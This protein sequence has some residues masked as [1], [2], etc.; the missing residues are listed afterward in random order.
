MATAEHPLSAGPH[1]CAPPGA[2]LP[3]APPRFTLDRP[4]LD[5]ALVAGDPV[6]T[7]LR[8]VRVLA[9][10]LSLI[11]VAPPRSVFEVAESVS[12]RV[13]DD[14]CAHAERDPAAARSGGWEY[15]HLG[16]G[17]WLAVAVYRVAH[18]VL[19]AFGGLPGVAVVARQMSEEARLATAVEI[20][21]AATI[22]P[23]LVIDHGAGTVIG[24]QAS[25]GRNVVI[26]HRVTIGS[27][28]A[29]DG[30]VTGR[31]H[32]TV[33]DNVTFSYGSA[34]LGQIEI[35][36]DVQV[37]PG[38]RITQPVPAGA[39]VRLIAGRQ[40]ILLAGESVWRDFK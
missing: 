23:R 1:A 32:P 31:R 27:R 33:G 24:E 11:D 38:C 13:F 29:A 17:S 28:D 40:Q 12:E 14:V 34:A 7:A 19:E 2:V 26:L 15:L 8:T 25:L 22:G 20:H 6:S 21:P 30:P 35:G 3:A 16:V 39:W 10:W 4:A 9:P 18:A 5:R 36:S 37:G